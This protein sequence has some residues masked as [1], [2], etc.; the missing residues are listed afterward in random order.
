MIGDV[1]VNIKN[2]INSRCQIPDARLKAV[3]GLGHLLSRTAT[4]P[5]I[6]WNLESEIWNRNAMPGS[7]TADLEFVA[8][9]IRGW[10]VHDNGNFFFVANYL[11]VNGSL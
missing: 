4:P 5:H 6:V 8:L 10:Q 2:K 9:L 11:Q 7:A 3:Y 1:L